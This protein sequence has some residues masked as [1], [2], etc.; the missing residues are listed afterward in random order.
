MNPNFNQNQQNPEEIEQNVKIKFEGDDALSKTV[1]KIGNKVSDLSTKFTLGNIAVKGFTK[2]TKTSNTTI[3]AFSKSL[4][5]ADKA[6]GKLYNSFTALQIGSVLVDGFREARRELSGLNL[7]LKT[8]EASGY[9]TKII[10]DF[11]KLSKAITGNGN[12]TEQFS[13]QALNAYNQYAKAQAEVA[14]LFGKGDKFVTSL[15]S[16]IQNLVN[17]ELDNAITSIQALGASYEAASAGFKSAA[18]NQEVMVAGLKLS[19]AGGADASS[20]MKALT[21]TIRAYNLEASDA[22]K[23]AVVLNKTIQL[24][25]TTLPEISNGFAQTAVVAKEAGISLDLQSALFIHG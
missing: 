19:K 12:A 24:G 22:A 5:V 9:S 4:G 13:F 14:V 25:I 21:Q 2:V 8:M 17:N 20:T 16:N 3:N 1:D 11:T 23:V 10:N 7:G 15:S 6:F 18:E